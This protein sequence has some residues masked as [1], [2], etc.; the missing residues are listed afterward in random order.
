VRTWRPDIVQFE[1]RIMAQFLPVIPR[2]VPCVLIEHD[3]HR[4]DAGVGAALRPFEG[5]AWRRL[6]RVAA[7]RARA[8][9]VLTEADRAAVV[10]ETGS[11]RVERIPLGYDV[12]VA[13]D[14][15]GRL[16]PKILS[17]GSFV[18]PPNVEGARWLATAVF[19][20]VRERVAG[21]SLQLLGS[22]PTA[23]VLALA[24]EGVAVL[25]DVDDVRPY[26]DE[27]AVVAA[28]VLSG[29]GMRV[30]M[31]EALAAGKA[32]VATPLAVEGM[33]LEDEK[34]VMIA[35][36]ELEFAAALVVLLE[37]RDRRVS[38]ARAARTWAEA[39]LDLDQQVRAYQTLY[40]EITR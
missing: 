25:G 38:L 16:P 40:D 15:G 33:A 3:P 13:L 37:D 24:G 19:P 8:I 6:G 30:K 14:P 31:L 35:E 18:H 27:A 36:T 29:G 4:S 5:H 12:P 1:Y 26:L 17:V 7:R 28:P 11:T 21:A 10:A 23:D 20:S 32:V 34:E 39:N 22:C 2:T 9:V